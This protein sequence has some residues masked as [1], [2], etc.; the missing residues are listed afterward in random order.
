MSSKDWD[1][2]MN[3]VFGSR[4]RFTGSTGEA[5]K[6]AP[7]SPPKRR[8]RWPPCSATPTP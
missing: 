2:L 7:E 1:T 6:P 5:A 4:G 8:T 3:G